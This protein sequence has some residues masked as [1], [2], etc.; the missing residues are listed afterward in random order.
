MTQAKQRDVSRKLRVLN[1]AKDG[2][3]V[4]RTCRSFGVSRETFYQLKLTFDY[5]LKQWESHQ[6]EITVAAINLCGNWQWRT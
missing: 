5:E 2:G 4:S 1:H 3:N 6:P